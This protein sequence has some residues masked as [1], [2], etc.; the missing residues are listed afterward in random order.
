MAQP[1]DPYQVASRPEMREHLMAKLDQLRVAPVAGIRPDVRDFRLD[2]CRALAQH[3]NPAGKE[4]RLFH[5]MG[6]EQRREAGA[7]PQ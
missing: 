7:L 5:I 1:P 2:V 4:Q 3:D 6:H